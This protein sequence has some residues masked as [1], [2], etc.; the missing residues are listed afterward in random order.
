M[1]LKANCMSQKN[2]WVNLFISIM[3]S[4]SDFTEGAKLWKNNFIVTI[5]YDK[6][7]Y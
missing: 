7:N 2:S 5:K 6:K 4:Y 3:G 1:N